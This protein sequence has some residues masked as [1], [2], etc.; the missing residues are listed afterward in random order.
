MG[1]KPVIIIGGG[2]I[3]LTCGVALQQSGV[4]VVIIDGDVAYEAPSWGNA[5]HIGVEQTR[6]LA[7]PAGVKHGL[8]QIFSSRSAASF[9]LQHVGTWGPFMARLL[10]AS[11]PKRSRAS[12]LALGGLLAQAMPAWRQMCTDI[13]VP[14]LLRED[15]HYELWESVKTVA[16]GEENWASNKAPSAAFSRVSRP[17][18]K[19]LQTMVKP[20][21][22]GGIRFTHS[23]QV[24]D[25]AALRG[26]LQRAFTQAGGV[27]KR[28]KVR[29]LQH[30]GGRAGVVCDDGTQMMAGRILVAAGIGSGA[31]LRPW[32][33]KVPLI[34]E[35]GYHIEGDA[36]AWPVNSPPMVFGDR[37]LIVTRFETRVRM[38][39]FVEFTGHSSPP[40]PRKWAQLRRHAQEI[41]LK[42][43]GEVREWRGARPTLPDYL[44]AIGKSEKVPDLYYAF[45]HQHLGLTMAAVTANLMA[46][47]MTDKTPPLN[48]GPFDI[49]RFS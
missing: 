41:G 31:L 49:T 7:S 20:P 39:S 10:C 12:E 44:P 14:N 21:L 13:G 9:P 29:A 17:Q 4:D 43:E 11:T 6:P 42:F 30:N 46:A 47:L 37:A 19:T 35:N 23:G 27:I 32:G 38:V 2:I 25:L 28:A 26:A 34:A 3:G 36:P 16:R 1:A 8:R 22:V 40:D 33:H 5:G 15:G 45:G 48:L 18:L 24:M